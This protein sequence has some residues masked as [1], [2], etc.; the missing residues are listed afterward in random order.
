[1]LDDEINQFKNKIPSEKVN[2]TKKKKKKKE[3]R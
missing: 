2:S 1:M 3:S